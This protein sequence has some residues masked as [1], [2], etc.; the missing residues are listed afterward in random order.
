MGL[1][2]IS[3]STFLITELR[4]TLGQ[5]HVQ[6]LDL[7]ADARQNAMCGD[8]SI[9]ELLRDLARSEDQWQARYRDILQQAGPSGREAGVDVPLPVNNAEEEPGVESEFEHRRART[10]AMLEEVDGT[11]PAALLEAV[12]QHVSEDRKATTAIA[13]CRKAYFREEQRP[14]LEEP[15]T[16]DPTPEPQD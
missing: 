10:I 2:T 14:D 15:I 8:K 13:E 1:E 12:R 5:L 6:V 4:Y 11:W 7:D 16:T 3:E 9:D